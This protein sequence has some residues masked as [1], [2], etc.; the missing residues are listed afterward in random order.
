MVSSE[1]K[2]SFGEDGQT[3]IIDD[4]EYEVGPEVYDVVSALYE[5]LEYQAVQLESISDL[6]R[7]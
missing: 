1:Y 2:L 7:H 5:I 6:R 4:Y 3:L